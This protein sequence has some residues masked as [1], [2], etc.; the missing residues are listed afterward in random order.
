MTATKVRTILNDESGQW[1]NH[2]LALMSEV[3]QIMGK[4]VINEADK[5]VPFEDGPL[6]A[7]HRLIPIRRLGSKVSSPI[8]IAII[9]GGGEIKYGDYQERGKRRDGTHVVKRYTTPGTGKEYLQDS[10]KR[11]T[12]RGIKWLLSNLSNS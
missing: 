2:Q 4:T 11:V 5:R 3:L 12:E 7:S 9:Y 1:F 6:K 10:G 8:G